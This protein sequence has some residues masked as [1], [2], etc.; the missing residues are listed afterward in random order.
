MELPPLS[1][2]MADST[3]STHTSMRKPLAIPWR[4][5]QSRS[6]GAT[7]LCAWE[8]DKAIYEKGENIS[9]TVALTQFLLHD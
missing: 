8:K 4:E 2:L 1:A 5:T 3:E 6:Y 9:Q 7:G